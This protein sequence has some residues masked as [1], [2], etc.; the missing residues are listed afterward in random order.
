MDYWLINHSDEDY[1]VSLEFIG[2]ASGKERLQVKAGD[3]VVYFG[4]GLVAGVFEASGLV[5]NEFGGWQ[6]KK[7]FQLRL[8]PVALAERDIVARP[9]RYKAQL[10]KP[11]EGSPRVFRLS[12]QEFGKIL[13]AVR[14][15]KELV[16]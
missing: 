9:L 7:P 3:M 4:R 13:R 10:E 14:E 11:V 15:G 12:E 16:Y 2:F 8:R 5:E 1:R 6:E